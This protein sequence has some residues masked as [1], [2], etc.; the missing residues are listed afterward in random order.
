M[1]PQIIHPERG[2][3]GNSQKPPARY[4]PIGD[5]E[6]YAL[7]SIDALLAAFIHI[8]DTPPDDPQENQ[9]WIDTSAL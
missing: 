6:R 4:I 5:G 8:G 2:G 7:V 9:L 3:L 1:V